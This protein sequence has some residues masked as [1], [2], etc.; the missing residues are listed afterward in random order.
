VTLTLHEHPFAAYYWKPLIALGERGVPFERRQVDTEEDRERL[1]EIWPTASI[2]VLVD[3]E[4]GGTLGE[5]SI[6]VEYLDRFGEAPLLI[7]AEPEAAL[8]ARLWDR[9]VDGGVA[10]PMQRI[11]ADALR[12]EADR[13]PFGV[14]EAC[15]ALERIYPVLDHQLRT[16]EYLSGPTF[17][18]A[19]TAAAPA[20]FYARVVHRWDEPSLPHLTRYFDALTARPSVAAVIDTARPFRE[21]FPLPWPDWVA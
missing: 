3:S 11:V 15:A 8:R 14:A 21:L 10:T 7:P 9:L 6:A 1:A 19:D 12:P 20:L 4:A 16:T 18:L 13:D 17:T 5:S 2:P